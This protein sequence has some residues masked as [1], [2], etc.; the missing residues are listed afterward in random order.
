MAERLEQVLQE[1]LA[2]ALLVAGQV[3][4]AVAREVTHGAGEVEAGD[5]PGTWHINGSQ[6]PKRPGRGNL[7]RVVGCSARWLSTSAAAGR[8]WRLCP[9]RSG[10]PPWAILHGGGRILDPSFASNA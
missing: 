4:L 1:D 8:R 3:L 5:G 6:I 7:A 2:F 9:G 10:W